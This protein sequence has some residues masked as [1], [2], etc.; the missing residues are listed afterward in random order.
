MPGRGSA[1]E[2][3][4]FLGLT[5]N[6]GLA[7]AIKTIKTHQLT[8]LHIKTSASWNASRSR[9]LD[10]RERERPTIW[11][12]LASMSTLSNDRSPD[13]QNWPGWDSL[14]RPSWWVDPP[15]P[16]QLLGAAM[17]VA[18]ALPCCCQ[19]ESGKMGKWTPIKTVQTKLI[20]TDE[21]GTTVVTRICTK[22]VLKIRAF[23]VETKLFA[24][25]PSLAWVV[26]AFWHVSSIFCGKNG[27][28]GAIRHL[29]VELGKAE[30]APIRCSTAQA[31]SSS[32]QDNLMFGNPDGISASITRQ[33][34]K[35]KAPRAV[36]RPWW[37]D[38]VQPLTD[39]AA[40]HVTFDQKSD[41][42]HPKWFK[43]GTYKWDW[44]LRLSTSL[45]R[46]SIMKP[47]R[48]ACWLGTK[49][50]PIIRLLVHCYL[51][52][53]KLD[54][55]QEVEATNPIRGRG[56][57][58]PSWFGWVSQRWAALGIPYDFTVR[59]VGLGASPI[60]PLD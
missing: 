60:P 20:R 53:P 17:G 23:L 14:R 10:G 6:G 59:S 51:G 45:C 58:R 40:E 44:T 57:L 36:R 52:P 27:W 11:I 34:S 41:V 33:I 25:R 50:C 7:R 16:Q 35:M 30:A 24:Y 49:L 55:S 2:C 8:N 12:H 1:T 13:W 56:D 47:S 31:L 9:F 54:Y 19:E 43:F 29:Q 15:K 5:L 21:H 18:V 38:H 42:E 4:F 3:F 22:F 46:R 28:R 26:A 32:Q 37:L 39:L 48:R